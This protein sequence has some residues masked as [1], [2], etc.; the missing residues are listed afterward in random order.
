MIVLIVFIFLAIQC[1]THVR[2]IEDL[3]LKGLNETIQRVMMLLDKDGIIQNI[4]NDSIYSEDVE[5]IR[6]NKDIGIYLEVYREL[7]DKGTESS[8]LLNNLIQF[9]SFQMISKYK[10][11]PIDGSQSQV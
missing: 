9:N 7:I 1:S 4:D 11:K 2:C 5:L 8:V 6:D 3:R 10:L